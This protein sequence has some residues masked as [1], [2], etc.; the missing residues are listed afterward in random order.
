ME[1]EHPLNLFA[2]LDGGRDEMRLSLRRDGDP[3]RFIGA[4]A[5]LNELE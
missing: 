3:L 1:S 5:V 2:R 4:V